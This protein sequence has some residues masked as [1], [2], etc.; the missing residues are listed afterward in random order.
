[1]ERIK[2]ILDKIEP[3]K[4]ELEFVK[5]EHYETNIAISKFSDEIALINSRRE[6]LWSDLKKL[7]SF[8]KELGNLTEMKYSNFKK[9]LSMISESNEDILMKANSIDKIE[10]ALKELKFHQTGDYLENGAKGFVYGGFFGSILKI[11]DSYKHN[12]EIEK[13]L[14]D[15][16]KQINKISIELKKSKEDFDL[17]RDYIMLCES[18]TI[19]YRN[20]INEISDFL[21]KKIFPELNIIKLFLLVHSIKEEVIFGTLN[22]ETK[23]SPTKISNLSESIYKKHYLFIQNTFLLFELVQSFFSQDVITK[24]ISSSKD[25]S[26]EE[27]VNNMTKVQIQIEYIKYQKEEVL[28]DIICEG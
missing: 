15:Y 9:E 21:E 1:M 22:N 26:E 24:L 20:L 25:S 7:Y 3:L 18:I 2:K 5:K 12:T 8:L 10:S 6:R 19:E 28:K 13:K 17:K 11:G 16:F 27:K 4:I 14:E 23:I